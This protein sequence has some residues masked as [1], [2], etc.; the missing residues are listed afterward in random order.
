MI[1]LAL[2]FLLYVASGWY[3]NFYMRPAYTDYLSFWG[4]GRLIIQG[5]SAAAYD[6]HRHSAAISE[7]MPVKGI[8]AFPYPPPFLFF[9]LP[10]SL[11]YY[12]F[13]FPAWVLTTLL[14]YL[15][16]TRRIAP[17]S[18]A[19]AQPALLITGFY[20]QT[21]FLLTGIFLGGAER[22]NR[23]PFF[24]GAILGLLVVKPHLALLLP[25]ALIAARAW[26]AIAG[27]LVSG[28]GLLLAGLLAFGWDA[29]LGFFGMSAVYADMV[30]EGRWPWRMLISP[31]AF[32]RY[33][34]VVA[35][36]AL[37]VHIAIAVG[38]AALT[39]IAWSREWN[40]RIGILAAASLL[41]PPYLLS[42]DSL[43]MVA[44]I[45]L[46]ASR[47]RSIVTAGA[48]W[49]LCLSPVLQHFRLYSG[50]N[51]VPVAAMTALLILAAPYLRRGSAPLRVGGSA[52]R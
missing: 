27:A 52:A 4:A 11:L 6:I 2:V 38:A 16:G 20:G 47:N 28:G 45:A 21:S 32:L 15:L 34:E 26:L 23:R 12:R 49:L 50:P 22:L 29:Y 51:L 30:A 43:L 5:E 39:G 24:A 7:I 17:M 44:S 35:P 33:F 41:I 10:F 18:T 13:A 14:V 48:I 1:G 36:V 46:L 8:L 40:E 25:V 42:Y 31:F 19:L 3:F 9:V 37:F